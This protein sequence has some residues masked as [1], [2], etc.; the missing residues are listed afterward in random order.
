LKK[1]KFVKFFYKKK[2]NG[3]GNS[4]I[5]LVQENR[6]ILLELETHSELCRFFIIFFKDNSS[7]DKYK[8]K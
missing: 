8:K 6:N 4:K 5:V 1:H 3:T 2:F 7:V